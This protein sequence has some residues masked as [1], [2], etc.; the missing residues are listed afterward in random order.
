MDNHM[1]REW[2]VNGKCGLWGYIGFRVCVLGDK[3]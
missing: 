3:P 1:E 2:N